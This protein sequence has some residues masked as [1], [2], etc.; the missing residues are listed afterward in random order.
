[1]VAEIRVPGTAGL[2]VAEVYSSGAAELRVAEI[3]NS[4]TIGLMVAE[5]Y[6]SGATKLRVVEIRNSSIVTDIYRK[7][8]AKRSESKGSNDDGGQREQQQCRLRLCC[9]FVAASGVGC[10]KGAAAIGGRWAAVC[11]IVSEEGSSGME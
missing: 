10:S 6:S 3:C 8:V 11:T 5:I 7:M 2:I 1:M 4:G 9:D